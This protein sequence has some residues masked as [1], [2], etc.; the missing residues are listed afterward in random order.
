M[1]MPVFVQICIYYHEN[2]LFV[3]A[4]PS[5]LNTIWIWRKAHCALVCPPKVVVHLVC[6]GVTIPI[7]LFRY[8]IHIWAW[9]ACQ[10]WCCSDG[11]LCTQWPWPS[12]L[13]HGT[14]MTL[15]SYVKALQCSTWKQ[16]AH[17]GVP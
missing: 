17:I 12:L 7:N 11:M 10:L 2:I 6:Y 9:W 16:L 1:K 14:T 4:V 5:L 15:H 3:Q 13:T 8:T